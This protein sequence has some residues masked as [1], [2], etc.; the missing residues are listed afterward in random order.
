MSRVRQNADSVATGSTQIAQGNNDLSS[1][2][3]EQAS[4]LEETAASMEQLGTAVRHNADNALQANQLA[5]GASTVAMRGGEVV[6][7]SC[8]R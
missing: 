4:A 8:R 5:Q 2:T 6:G 1:R 7:R 3:E